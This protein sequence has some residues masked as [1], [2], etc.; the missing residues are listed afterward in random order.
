[1]YPQNEDSTLVGIHQTTRRHI[2]EDSRRNFFEQL[3]HNQLLLLTF[4]W[5]TLQRCRIRTTQRRMVDLLMDDE[6]EGIWKEV[7]MS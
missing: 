6:S 3:S 2:P 7:V 1:M 5:D 4:L